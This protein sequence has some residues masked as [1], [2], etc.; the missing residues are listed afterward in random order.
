M[1]PPTEMLQAVLHDVWAGLV[2]R[3]WLLALLGFV[4]AV[5]MVRVCRAVIHSGH[6]KDDNRTFSR[7]EKAHIIARAG[8]RCE[9]RSRISGRCRVS[10][11]LEADH[12]H[13][14]S[15]G[16]WTAVQNGQALCRPHNKSK[17][18]RV[19]WDWQ[20]RQLARRRATYFP[21]GTATDVVRHRPRTIRAAQT[22]EARQ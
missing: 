1:S 14:H 7:T 12:V 9:H 15:R 20:L 8:G 13:P 22:S 5:R 11:R 16:G 2:D 19:P 17:S 4:I 6:P 18:A 10:E 3:P 21:P